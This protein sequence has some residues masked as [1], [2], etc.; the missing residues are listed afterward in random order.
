MNAWLMAVASTLICSSGERPAS[1]S[2]WKFT[3]T[4]ITKVYWPLSMAWS[5]RSGGRG[6]AGWNSGGCSASVSLRESRL[7][8]SSTTATLALCT[9]ITEPAAGM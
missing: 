1:R 4:L 2:L 9:P 6:T 7:W 3:G 8:S 5:R